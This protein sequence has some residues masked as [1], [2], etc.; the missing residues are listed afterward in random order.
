MTDED[1]PPDD[2]D[3]ALL[4][5]RAQAVMAFKDGVDTTGMTR[6]ARSP[7]ERAYLESIGFQTPFIETGAPRTDAALDVLR[8]GTVD[9]KTVS[10]DVS[11][12]LFEAFH[13]AAAVDGRPATHV[14]ARAIDLYA[15]LPA[16]ARKGFA[17]LRAHATQ[18]E[19]ESLLLEFT[20]AVGRTQMVV[21]TREIHD[22][23]EPE[24]LAELGRTVEAIE[25]ST[26]RATGERPAEDASVDAEGPAT[27]VGAAP[28]NA[29]IDELL[30]LG[31]KVLAETVAES[32]GVWTKEVALGHLAIS[33]PELDSFR[34]VGRVLALPQSDGT[35]VYPVAQFVRPA[36]EAEVWRPFPVIL[37]IAHLAY[38]K[39]WSAELL[40]TFLGTP[41]DLLATD[42]RAA[43][44]P[45]EALID[46][47]WAVV[48]ALMEWV[49]T[50]SDAGAPLAQ[51]SQQGI[52]VVEEGR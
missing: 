50:E 4:L 29:K 26:P 52:P 40:V 35:F 47:D 32:G 9:K 49:L 17:Y 8:G 2:R 27:P 1:L 37:K 18:Q 15:L 13:R 6:P 43:R 12:A 25:S 36:S 44:T 45:F 19:L 24:V 33:E 7:E 16:S 39:A 31:R 48:L 14:A 42:G 3:R 41:Q 21:A 10:A 22:S 46:G 5:Q 23:L 38:A 30:R 20:R 51:A 34:G 28:T 11:E